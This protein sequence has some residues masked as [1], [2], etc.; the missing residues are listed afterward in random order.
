VKWHIHG[1]ESHEG[2]YNKFIFVLKHSLQPLLELFH[3]AIT[4]GMTSAHGSAVH[5]RVWCKQDAY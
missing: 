5:Y 2:G 3:T 1:N 4:G